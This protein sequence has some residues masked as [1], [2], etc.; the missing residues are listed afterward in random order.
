M[1]DTPSSPSKKRHRDDPVDATSA[2][3]DRRKRRKF[4]RVSHPYS[5]KLSRLKRS[6]SEG[7][8]ARARGI[9]DLEDTDLPPSYY[10]GKKPKQSY[11]WPISLLRRTTMLRLQCHLPDVHPPLEFFP[12]ALSVEKFRVPSASTSRLEVLECNHIFIQHQDIPE[13]IE[14]AVKDVLRRPS[15][16]PLLNDAEARRIA[17]VA[18]QPRAVAKRMSSEASLWQ[19]S[20]IRPPT[21]LN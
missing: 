2:D 6:R 5:A 19:Y 21:P 17:T 8:I 1:V 14:S 10:F 11:I 4:S 12:N 18:G 16:I 13:C 15:S 3:Q 20:P 9:S 7:D